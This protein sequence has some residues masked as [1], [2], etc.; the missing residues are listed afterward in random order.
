VREALQLL[1]CEKLVVGALV[2]PMER[3]Q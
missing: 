3:I 2:P 1:E